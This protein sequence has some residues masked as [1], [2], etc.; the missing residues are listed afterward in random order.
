MGI[1]LTHLCW[2]G[3]PS[4]LAPLR[5][6]CTTSSTVNSL[7]LK[8]QTIVCTQKYQLAHRHSVCFTLPS[9]PKFQATT[10]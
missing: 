4:P 6:L 10:K 8:T 3:P 9:Q 7:F 5:G 2:V 1:I